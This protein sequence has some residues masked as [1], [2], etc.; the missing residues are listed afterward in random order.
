[1]NVVIFSEYIV[2]E[3]DG[4]SKYFDVQSINESDNFDISRHA[5]IINWVD[6]VLKQNELNSLFSPGGC[7][8][9]HNIF[10]FSN[11]TE[12]PHLETIEYIEKLL[13][14]ISGLIGVSDPV[15]IFHD[16]S[17]INGSPDLVNNFYNIIGG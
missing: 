10:T 12:V 17:D 3:V 9:H 14:Y 4:L 13:I 5:P 1:M 16:H 2:C 7:L 8:N 15:L 6:I 11:N